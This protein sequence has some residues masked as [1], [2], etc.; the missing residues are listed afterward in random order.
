MGI[1]KT[2][3]AL[4][5][6]YQAL[7][8]G[9]ATG[10]YFA[11]PTQLTSDKIYDR[12]NSFL[13]KVLAEDCKFRSLLLHS[14]AWLRDTELGEEGMPGNGWFSSRK[15]GL[16]APFAV[17]TIDQALMGVMN[18]KHG[19]VRTFG[20]AGKVVILDEV[21]SYDSYTGTIIDKL[22]QTLRELD[23]TVIILSATLTAERR[24]RLAWARE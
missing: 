22:V 13:A 17:G 6:A 9:S 7:T 2:E 16:L 12:M 3:A 10:I 19:F 11:L 23:C 4:Y 8:Q 24:V 15:R 18:V 1:G 20:L 5:A 21:H 14:S